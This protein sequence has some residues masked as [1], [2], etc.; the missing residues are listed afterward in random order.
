MHVCMYAYIDIYY[1]YVFNK[2]GSTDEELFCYCTSFP[3]LYLFISLAITN[4]AKILQFCLHPLYNVTFHILPINNCGWCS[5]SLNL[6]WLCDLFWLRE[7]CASSEPQAQEALCSHSLTSPLLCELAG[8]SLLDDGRTR[9]PE[10]SCLSKIS[11][12]D[13][14]LNPDTG[15][16]PTKSSTVD[17][18]T[19]EQ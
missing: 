18:R 6:D 14:R 7:Q 15:G 13:L 8:T 19:C 2:S 10:P 16:S 9:G 12:A 11:Q 4:I 5:L 1:F 17:P 3:S